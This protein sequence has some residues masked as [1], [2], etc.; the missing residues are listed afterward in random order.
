MKNHTIKTMFRGWL[1][2]FIRKT[3]HIPQYT[4]RAFDAAKITETHAGWKSEPQNLNKDLRLSLRVLRS[5]SRG[6]ALNND[7]VKRFLGMVKTNIIGPNGVRLQVKAKRV[8]GTDN[9]RASVVIEEGW[10]RFSK[11]G[12]CDVTETLSMFGIENLAI[13]TIARD[14]EVFI[15]IIRSEKSAKT[16][17]GIRFQFIDAELIDENH[18]EKLRNGNVV[19]MGVE[20]D[21]FGKRVA[22]WAKSGDVEGQ[23]SAARNRIRIP[24]EEM[25]H[26]F[27]NMDALQV[28]GVPWVHASMLR[29]NILGG[30][31]EAGLISARTGACKMGFY[32]SDGGESMNVDGVRKD[33]TLLQNAEPGAFQELPPGM[34]FVAY[35][36]NHPSGEHAPFVKSVLRG[37]ASGLNVSY[38]SLANDLEGVNFSSIRAGVQDERDTWRML[39]RLMI[40]SIHQPIFE[41]WLEWAIIVN[42]LD[43]IRLFNFDLCN[44]VKWHPRGWQWVDPLKDTQ[45]NV[46]ANGAGH[47]TKRAVC[48]EQGL[49]LED[50]F[51]QLKE[52][53]ELADSLGLS[54]V[55]GKNK[56][57]ANKP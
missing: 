43:D 20:I 34:D 50:V 47:K 4:G 44:N 28:R 27:L 8:E 56:P 53:K 49:E 30:Y 29:L 45:S 40:E 18:H 35:D 36:P 54:F 6:Q 24:A 3:F 22:Y 12:K 7:Y 9:K 5:R 23:V 33:G 13:E 11:K 48:A 14:G 21:A 1:N 15:R 51:E 10:K 39:Q 37:I 16:P 55:T 31:E 41:A 17:F 19:Y 57:S 52:E 26:A 42:A 2:T 38:H 25:I 46:L 32:K